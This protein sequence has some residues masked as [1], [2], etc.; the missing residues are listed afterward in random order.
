MIDHSRYY[1]PKPKAPPTEKELKTHKNQ[2]DAQYKIDQYGLD[3]VCQDIMGGESMAVIAAKLGVHPS[4]VVYWVSKSPE[5]Q[6]RTREA[7]AHAAIL[8]DELAEHKLNTAEDKMSLMRA[9]ELASHYRWRARCV[10]PKQYGD[11]ITSEVSGPDGS[12]LQISSLDLK[13]L[14]DEEL[15][16]VEKLMM[17]A[18]A[19]RPTSDS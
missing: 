15:A 2:W 6:T 10:A 12:P 4:A 9:K 19:T 7:R 11:K 1:S 18:A 8:W 3:A 16:V 13:N 5:R 17:K 14:T